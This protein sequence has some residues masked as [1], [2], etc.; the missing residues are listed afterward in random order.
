MR[1]LCI[2]MVAALVPDS[3][4]ATDCSKLASLA[5]PGARIVS[6]VS[7]ARGAFHE[8]GAGGASRSYGDLPEFCEARGIATPVPGSRIG[9]TVWLPSVA[10]WSRRLHMVGNGGYGSNLYYEQLAARVRRG[11]VA[12]ATDTGHT[13]RELT[14][15]KDNPEAIVDWG[16][17]RRP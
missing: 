11:D 7:I 9:F 17:A 3:A 5:L 12:V 16:T 4:A 14:F 10:S 6:A 13:G 1:A 2:L 8:P 15:G